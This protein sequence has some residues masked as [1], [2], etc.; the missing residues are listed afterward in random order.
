MYVCTRMY[1]CPLRGS[2]AARCWT[3]FSF[4]TVE[5]LTLKIRVY[6]AILFFYF[7]LFFLKVGFSW[8]GVFLILKCTK[9]LR[10]GHHFQDSPQVCFIT[11]TIISSITFLSLLNQLPGLTDTDRGVTAESFSYPEQTTQHRVM[12]RRRSSCAG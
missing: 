4:A 10:S 8:G 2:D 9:I 3:L 7:S 11:K 12:H 1:A 5:C 6:N